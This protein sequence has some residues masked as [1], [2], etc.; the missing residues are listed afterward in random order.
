MERLTAHPLNGFHAGE[1]RDALVGPWGPAYS[2]LPT[3]DGVS[4]LSR[5][6]RYDGTDC[7]CCFSVYANALGGR[8]AVASYSP[9]QRLGR[10]GKRQQ[11]L[12]VADWL[13]GGRLPLLIEQPVRVAPFIRKS[14]DDQRVAVVLLNMGLDPTGPLTLRLRAAP[15]EVRMLGL[16]APLP[17][18]HTADETVLSLPSIPAWQTAILLGT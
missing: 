12:R 5:L 14:D 11:V 6:W 2:L 10:T 4:D 13:A 16:A 17:L 1:E 15:R 8:V 18:H 3:E 7:G 9:W